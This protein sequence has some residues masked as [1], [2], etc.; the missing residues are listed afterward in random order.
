MRWNARE[1]RLSVQI[2]CRTKSPFVVRRGPRC[3]SRLWQGAAVACDWCNNKD[4]STSIAGGFHLGGSDVLW[5]A[6]MPW[7][8]YQRPRTPLST[9]T[10][11]YYMGPAEVDSSP[12][13]PLGYVRPLRWHKNPRRRRRSFGAGRVKQMIPAQFQCSE[14]ARTTK[15]QRVSGTRSFKL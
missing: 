12:I 8:Q 3:H 15:A 10:G 6:W 9:T 1:K 2:F 4:V 5:R 11:A 14:R 13:V 7:F